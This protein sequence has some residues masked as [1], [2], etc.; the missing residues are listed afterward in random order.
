M[1]D[2]EIV[3]DTTRK[4]CKAS[5]VMEVTRIIENLNDT[6]N[7]VRK[8]AEARKAEIYARQRGE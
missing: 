1:I 7:F 4:I 8:I 6:V 3:V 2:G 5:C